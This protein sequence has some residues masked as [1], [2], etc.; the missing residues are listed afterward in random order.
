MHPDPWLDRW[1]EDVLNSVRQHLGDRQYVAISE[2]RAITAALF[3][4]ATPY[5]DSAKLAP[6]QEAVE[7]L[8]SRLT[9]TSG[10]TW[11]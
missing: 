2:A 6:I 10:A 1:T 7:R 5:I 8:L 3:L 9:D 11:H 4:A